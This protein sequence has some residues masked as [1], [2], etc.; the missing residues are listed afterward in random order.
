MNIGIIIF[1]Q[2]GNTKTAADKIRDKLSAGGHNV[3]IERIKISGPVSENESDIRFEYLPDA[4][5]YDGLVVCSPVH[6]FSL[7]AV[8][9][10][11]L[12][13]MNIKPGIKTS[14]LVTQYFP[15]AWMG[16]NR[17]IRQMKKICSQRGLDSSV[18]AVINWSAAAKREK[19]ITEAAV[20]ISGMFTADKN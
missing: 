6:A 3:K 2:T 10:A 13:K 5:R 15:F 16:G 17:A 7:A 11:A 20:K 12:K 18:S 8:M 4:A 19:Q 9:R 1:S 14:C